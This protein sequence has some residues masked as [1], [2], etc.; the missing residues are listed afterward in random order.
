MRKY[1]FYILAV[2]VIGAVYAFNNPVVDFK[3]DTKGGIHFKEMTWAETLAEAK[4]QNKLI[5]VDVYAAWCGPCKKLKK[6]TFSDEKVGTF[7]N[8]NFINV[9]FD[10]E[11]EEGLKLMN[12]YGLTSYPSLLFVDYKGDVVLKTGG[13]YNSKVFLGMGELVLKKN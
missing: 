3:V 8:E 12:L 6:Y 5:F 1:S 11:Q 7:Y 4:K 13:Y 10:G 9:A 2:L